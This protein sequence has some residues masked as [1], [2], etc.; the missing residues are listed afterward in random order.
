VGAQVQEIIVQEH[1]VPLS[2][3]HDNR[4]KAKLPRCG[5]NN[6]CIKHDFVIEIGVQNKYPGAMSTQVQWCGGSP[7]QYS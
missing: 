3:L 5:Q 1:F 4:P 7:I 6:V 2:I